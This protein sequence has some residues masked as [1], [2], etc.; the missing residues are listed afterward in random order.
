MLET[1]S[2]SCFRHIVQCI[3][4]AISSKRRKKYVLFFKY[5]Y[6]T[7]MRK[8]EAQKHPLRICCDI[9]CFG[10][11]IFRKGSVTWGVI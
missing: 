9:Y 6:P 2:K 7:S 5:S 8:L 4:L 10:G 11:V 3:T 1:T